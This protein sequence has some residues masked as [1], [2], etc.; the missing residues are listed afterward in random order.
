M[1][2][3][4]Y[5]FRMGNAYSSKNAKTLSSTELLKKAIFFRFSEILIYPL[6]RLGLKIQPFEK[7]NKTP[8]GTA[9]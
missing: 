8:V 1:D 5:C 6:L 4:V 9:P 2:C 3:V 7:H